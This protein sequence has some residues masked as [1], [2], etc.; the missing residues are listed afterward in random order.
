[1]SGTGAGLVDQRGVVEIGRGQHAG[2]GAAHAQPADQGARVD[3]LDA[4]DVVLG[5]GSR[6]GGRCERKLLGMRVSSRTMKP[7]TCGRRRFAVLGVDAVVADE[8]IGHGDDLALVGRIGQHF[9]VAGHAGVEDDLAE[10]LAGRAEAAAGVDRAVFES[11]FRHV[12]R[13]R[14]P[15]RLFAPPFRGPRSASSPLYERRQAPD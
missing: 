1:M 14:I 7:S 10:G 9:L 12:C 8:R 2:H 13:H 11:Q 6:R 15:R 5:A 4:E 3:A